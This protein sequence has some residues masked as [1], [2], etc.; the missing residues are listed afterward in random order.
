VTNTNG[1]VYKAMVMNTVEADQ[2]T[3]THSLKSCD[4]RPSA[5]GGYQF[6]NGDAIDTGGWCAYVFP[7]NS[8][9]PRC[10]TV[11]DGGDGRFENSYA[12]W[13]GFEAEGGGLLKSQRV[14]GTTRITCK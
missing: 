7:E 2:V 14:T 10:K 1:T 3:Y 9:V 12:V 8:D 11:A 5:S 6:V 4:I 13:G